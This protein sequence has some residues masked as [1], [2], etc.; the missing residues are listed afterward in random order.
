MS[1]IDVNQ[2]VAISD[3]AIEDVHAVRIDLNFKFEVNFKTLTSSSEYSMQYIITDNPIVMKKVLTGV[4][5][6]ISKVIVDFF[7]KEGT[8]QIDNNNDF[9]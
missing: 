6:K 3:P 7:N 8:F 1:F 5:S 9:K 4:I 2:L